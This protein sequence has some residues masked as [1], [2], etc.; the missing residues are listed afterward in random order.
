MIGQSTARRGGPARRRGGRTP[1]VRFALPAD[2]SDART[3]LGEIG[4]D[5]AV[6]ELQRRG[7]AVLARRYRRRGGEIDIVAVDGPTIVFVEVKA[8]DGNRFGT[9]AEAVTLVKRRR[10]MAAARDYVTRHRC[11]D[12]PCRF[13]VVAIELENEVAGIE[14]FRNAF[15]VAG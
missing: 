3:R 2:M 11:Q 9:A 12:R 10:L 14:V 6:E 1:G 5:L 8:R 15:D 4:E 13:D 7:Y